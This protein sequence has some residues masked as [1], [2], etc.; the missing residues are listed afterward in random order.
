[1]QSPLRSASAEGPGGGFTLIVAAVL[2]LLIL[3]SQAVFIVPAG[4]VAVVTTLGKVTGAPRAPGANFKAP[5]VQAISLFDVRTQVRPEQFSTLTKDLQVIQATE[6]GELL[7]RPFSDP[8]HFIC[9]T[10]CNFR[11]R[12]WRLPK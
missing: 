2:G 11:E 1:M 12:C 5:L 3:L 9:R 7:P 4:N 8:S 6:A 10:R